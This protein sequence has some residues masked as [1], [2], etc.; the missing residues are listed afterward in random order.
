MNIPIENLAAWDLRIKSDLIT[1]RGRF[2]K[3]WAEAYALVRNSD[4][5][6]N[7]RGNRT[8]NL[9]SEFVRMLHSR[10]LASTPEITIDPDDPDFK[11][12]AENAAIVAKSVSR[13]AKV[14]DAFKDALTSATWASQGWVEVGHPMDPYSLDMMRK[15]T[16]PNVEGGRE[17]IDRFE[18]VPAEDLQMRGVPTE[19]V[20]AFSPLESFPSEAEAPE[21][22]PIFSPLFGYPWAASVDPRYVITNLNAK[23][24]DGMDYICRFRFLTIK[25][26][27]T[28]SG[29]QYPNKAAVNSEFIYLF[30]TVEGD[31]IKLFPNMLMVAELWIIRDRND[32]EYNNY[33]VSYIFNEPHNVVKCAKAPLGGMIPLTPVK[34]SKL[35][36]MYD[37]TLAEELKPYADAFDKGSKAMFRSL[38]RMLNRKWGVP[39]AAGLADG[40]DKKLNDDNYNGVIKINDPNAVKRIG[41]ESFD[42]NLIAAINWIKGQAQSSSGSSDLDRGQAVKDITARQTQALLDAT[43]INV[44]GMKDPVNDAL[45]QV[46]LKLMHLVAMFNSTRSRKYQYGSDMVSMDAGTHDF[47]SSYIYEVQLRD[48]DQSATTEDRLILVQ[49]LRLLYSDTG[50]A[51]LQFFNQPEIARQ[52]VR[53]FG[54]TPTMLMA[55][56]GAAAIPAVNPAL[57]AALQDISGLAPQGQGMMDAG[58]GQHPERQMGDRG[59]NLGNALSGALRTGT[60]TGE[61]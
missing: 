30:E 3:K 16:T 61:M 57:S 17:N 28:M 55:R 6:S 29:Y 7:A 15:L 19:E 43:G 49:A 22:A 31:N 58:A 46:V 26:L 10:L 9:A 21:P 5:S 11:D 51:L 60:G 37:I 56:A 33:F 35:K 18:E 2:D 44:E 52:F 23:D 20:D 1:R 54:L 47:T 36:K 27:Q 41:E 38:N 39:D 32:P 42:Q 50:G 13:I 40:E 4:D 24:R 48:A 59:V 12:Q 25:E 14:P 34:L 53:K 8:G 45:V